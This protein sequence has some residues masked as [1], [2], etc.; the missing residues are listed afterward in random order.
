V[1]RAGL[2]LL[3]RWLGWLLAASG[4]RP[5]PS[6]QEAGSPA[7]LP[8]NKRKLG[9]L[10]MSRPELEEPEQELKKWHG[11]PVYS[12]IQDFVA[13]MWGATDNNDNVTMLQTD[14]TR[15]E[16]VVAGKGT[17][18]KKKP[19]MNFVKNKVQVK[20]GGDGTPS[21]TIQ[22][23]NENEEVELVELE[24]VQDSPDDV[25]MMSFADKQVFFAKEIA[26]EKAKAEAGAGSK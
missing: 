8:A 21:R 17:F 13:K 24:E 7:G 14:E 25:A 16:Q 3:G 26:Q 10:D 5:P 15:V 1:V 18:W 9:E 6:V 4:L 11:D 22:D 19:E 20:F 12:A 23:L 2:L